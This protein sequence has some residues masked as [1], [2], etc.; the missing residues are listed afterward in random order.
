M[1]A[2]E[3]QADAIWEGVSP[4]V[5]ARWRGSTGGNLKQA[6]VTTIAYQVHDLH[7]SS[8]AG[9]VASSTGLTVS[10]VIFDTLQTDERWTKDTTGYNF[11]HTLGS[12]VFATGGHTYRVEYRLTESSTGAE[13]SKV[14]YRM[15]AKNSLMD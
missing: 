8:T 7:V 11:R 4:T 2:S 6:N 10:D 3:I 9:A 12:T 13:V 1:D 14:V 15:F 5:M